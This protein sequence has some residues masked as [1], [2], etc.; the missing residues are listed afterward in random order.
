MGHSCKLTP[1]DEYLNGRGV[2]S[3]MGDTVGESMSQ[4]VLIIN[5]KVI[6]RIVKTSDQTKHYG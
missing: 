1:K 5:H 3:V 2:N 6:I 4:S